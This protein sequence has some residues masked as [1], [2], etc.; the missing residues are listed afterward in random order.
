[1][2]VNA[3]IF[4]ISLL[5]LF[6]I[7]YFCMFGLLSY[8]YN[9]CNVRFCVLYTYSR[10]FLFFF[11]FSSPPHYTFSLFLGFM[12][13][14]ITHFIF[15]LI[16]ANNHMIIIFF[17]VVNFLIFTYFFEYFSFFTFVIFNFNF[18]LSN[19]MYIIFPF[20]LFESV[21]SLMHS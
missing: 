2:A 19:I 12:I 7:C 16:V 21:F 13:L 20:N 18:L 10:I 15:F 9:S 17:N 3:W 8:L 1:M 4:E 14:F 6:L 5:F 11:S